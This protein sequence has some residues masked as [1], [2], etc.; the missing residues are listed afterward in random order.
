MGM[1]LEDVLGKKVLVGVVPASRRDRSLSSGGGLG[2]GCHGL[3][4]LTGLNVLFS[5]LTLLVIINFYYYY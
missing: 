2:S 1:Q 5:P 3:E 4:P